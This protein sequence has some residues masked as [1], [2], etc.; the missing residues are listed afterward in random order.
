MGELALP[1]RPDW[2][3]GHELAIQWSAEPATPALVERNLQTLALAMEQ[4]HGDVSLALDVRDE[5]QRHQVAYA[6]MG[7]R[8]ASVR[9]NSIVMRAERIVALAPKGTPEHPPAVHTN[10]GVSMKSDSVAD[11]NQ[12]SRIRK[13]HEDV[14]DEKF[15][16]IIAESLETEVPVTR[17]AIERAGQQ[18]RADANAERKADLAANPPPLPQGVYR[19]LVIDPPWPVDKIT[20]AGATPHNSAGGMEYPVMQVSEI[21][22]LPVADLLA[23]DAWVFLWTTQRFLRD[24]QDM[25]ESD[26]GLRYRFVMVWHKDS[27]FQPFGLPKYNAEFVVVAANGKPEFVDLKAFS[28]AFNAPSRGHSVKPLEFYELLERVTVAPRLSMFERSERPGFGVWG[29]EVAS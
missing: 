18:A 16:E 3:Q 24:A 10:A 29:N 13:A 11:Q 9:A 25:V 19:T 2:A 23:P 14:S 21:R 20:A 8:G 7:L 5:A 6:A 1:T 15:E 22:E 26:W 4:A 17:K 28:I 12:R 27:G